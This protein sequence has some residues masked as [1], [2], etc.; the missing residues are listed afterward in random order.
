[1]QVERAD[2]DQFS[3]GRVSNAWVTYPIDLDNLRKL[4]LN[5]DSDVGYGLYLNERSLLD[6][7]A[8][9]QVV[10]EVKAHQANDR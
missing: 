5:R 2:F 10:G 4:G 8:T 6:R 1:M 7:P 9:Y 3:G